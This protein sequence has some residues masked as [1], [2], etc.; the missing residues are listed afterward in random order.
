MPIAMDHRNLVALRRAG[1]RE[2][3]FRAARVVRPLCPVGVY[4]RGGKRR[5]LHFDRAFVGAG[6]WTPRHAGRFVQ[7]ND[8][9]RSA[10]AT[11]P[12]RHT[13]ARAT[14]TF[15]YR[16]IRSANVRC[17]AGAPCIR[18]LG[19][20][21]DDVWVF[22]NN[23]LAVDLGEIHTPVSGSVTLDGSSA[24]R[25]ALEDG[26]VYEIRVFHAER[27]TTVLRRWHQAS[28]RRL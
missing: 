17:V 7:S 5:G 6:W 28:R 10:C 13:R 18:P 26:K 8:H 21:S 20:A 2:P 1:L 24:N 9:A 14:G 27:Q 16:T 15:H 11:S 12:C 4:R 22:I 23:R 3:P 19:I 25:F